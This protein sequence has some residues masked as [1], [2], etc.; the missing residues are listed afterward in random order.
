MNSSELIGKK[1]K[2][3]SPITNGETYGEIKKIYN[4]R[5]DRYP[6]LETTQNNVYPLNE[7]LIFIDDNYKKIEIDS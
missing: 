3:I 7:C 1:F 5:N 2:W 4:Y 6:L